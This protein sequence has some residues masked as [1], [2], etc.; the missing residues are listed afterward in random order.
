MRLAEKLKAWLRVRGRSF[1]HFSFLIRRMTG[2]I[3][4]IYLLVHMADISTI[5][6]GEEAYNSLLRVFASPLG[7]VF[8][9]FLWATLV[10]HGSL[11]VYSVLAE[12][13]LLLD[14]RKYLL[15]VAWIVALVLMFVGSWVIID[16]LAV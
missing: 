11:G 6:L 13:G 8:D 9:V 10:L 5:L 1:D 16:V 7:L 2:I 4:A 14:K 12:T 3:L 15:Y